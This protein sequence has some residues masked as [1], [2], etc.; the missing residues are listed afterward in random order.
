MTDDAKKSRDPA[1]DAPTAD[2]LRAARWEP[3]VDTREFRRPL[4]WLAIGV[5]LAIG[6][7]IALYVHHRS[8]EERRDLRAQLVH[9]Y[10]TKIAS[11]ARGVTRFRAAVERMIQQ[12]ARTHAPDAL[13]P[14]FTLDSL[15]GKPGVYIRLRESEAA[16]S[17]TISHALEIMEPDAIPHCLGITPVAMRTLYT[18][19]RPITAA[20]LASARNTTDALR[21]TVRIDEVDRFAS[22]DLPVLQSIAASDYVLVTIIRGESRATDEVDVFVFDAHSG[23]VRLATNTKANGYL[24]TARVEGY[25]APTP[26]QEALARSGAVDCSIAAQARTRT[27]EFG[28]AEA[29]GPSAPTPTPIDAGVAHD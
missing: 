25:R 3:E 15:R 12:A 26:S 22:R 18:R 9:D 6:L 4:P 11:G 28:A 5:V 7:A 13:E 2:P 23:A 10:G 1:P 27:G 24:I 20:W 17:E 21:L 19:Y 14:G 8:T 16:T 29:S